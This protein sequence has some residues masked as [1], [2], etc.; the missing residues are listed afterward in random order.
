MVAL[1]KSDPLWILIAMWLWSTAA[2][3][4]TLPVTKEM[5]MQ[6]SYRV[7]LRTPCN[8]DK[9]LDKISVNAV[10]GD[11]GEYTDVRSFSIIDRNS[12]VSVPIMGEV[13]ADGNNLYLF[14]RD[15]VPMMHDRKYLYHL[16][17]DIGT[18]K[19]RCKQD[20]GFG[21]ITR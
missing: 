16:N 20:F 6:D 15:G 3:G 17:V 13:M 4:D 2:A 19:T 18:T 8:W 12:M 5:I 21:S 1:R 14:F 9:D 11:P 10:Y 7:V